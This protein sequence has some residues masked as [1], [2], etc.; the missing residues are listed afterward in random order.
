MS[1]TPEERNALCVIARDAVKAAVEGVAY[2]PEKP[3][4]PALKREGGGCFVTLKT[5]G[6]LRGCLGCF[7]SEKPLFQTVADYA[8]HSALEDSRFAANRLRTGELTKLDIEISVLSP[9]TPCPDPMAIRLGVDGI[10]IRQGFRSGVFLPQVATE[11]G[12]SVEEFWGHCARDK[13]GL[14]WDAWR[15]KNVELITFTAEVVACGD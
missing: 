13:A 4:S 15:D 10:Y 12:W 14:A 7:A 9:L 2:H 3:A 1:L 5:A 6:K 11:T 8:R